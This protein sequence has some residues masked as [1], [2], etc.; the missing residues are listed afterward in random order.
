MMKLKHTFILLLLPL[1]LLTAAFQDFEPIGQPTNPLASIS[2][3]PPIYLMRGQMPI[4][5]TANMPDMIGY[6]I[7][8]RALGSDFTTQE[9]TSG[10]TPATLPV[11]TAIVNG[12]LGTWDTTL[13]NDGAYEIRLTV[14]TRTE[15]IY[16]RVSPLRIE[17]NP[18][19]FIQLPGVPV[20]TQE[21]VLPTFAP[22]PTAVSTNP[23]V[24]PINVNVNVRSGD[25]TAYPTVGSLLVGDTANIL[26]RSSRGSGWW[27]ILLPNNRQGWVS[28]DVV[29]ENG[30]LSNI[31]FVDPPPIP[32]TPTPVPPTAA[33]F[34]DATISNVRFDRAIKQN[35]SFQVIVTVYNN[36]AV[37]LPQVT[38]ACNFTPMNA[39][40]SAPLGGLG[41]FS[42]IDV[43]IV[44]QLTS[45]GGSNVTANC[46]VDVNNLVQET[47]EQNNYFNL[48]SFLAA[49]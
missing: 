1:L 40:F 14:I 30:D 19:P 5:G 28:P 49:P 42:Q 24:T 34:P 8:F 33:P 32:A 41:P 10:W 46:A 26:G 29:L 13:V 17:N 22:P 31:P 44:A 2:F 18:P 7:E 25:S 3:P 37:S 35:E 4:Y 47:N 12:L 45:G 23:T 9:D 11:N 6:Y 43:A 16:S 36:S 48:T 20:V 38:V 21:V 27:Y 15:T 39:F